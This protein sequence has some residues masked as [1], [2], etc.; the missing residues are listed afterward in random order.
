MFQRQRLEEILKSRGFFL[1]AL[2][3]FFTLSLLVRLWWTLSVQPPAKALYS[4]ML[5]YTDRAQD[6]VKGQ[7]VRNPYL[8]VVAYGAHYFY[9]AEMLVFGPENYK[10]MSVVGAV[11]SAVTVALVMAAARFCFN[12]V[13][14]PYLVGLLCAIWYPAIVFT[15]F[16]STELPFS[17]FL[18]LSILLSFWLLWTRRPA[19]VAVIAGVAYAAGFAIRPQLLMTFL[20]FFVWVV[21]RRNKITAFRWRWLPAFALPVI[22]VVVFSVYRYHYFTGRYA[23]I[24]SNSAVG[25][26]L[27]SSRYKRI[28]CEMDEFGGVRRTRKFQPPSAR[29]LGYTEQF[30]FEGYIGDS[31][32]LN[33]ERKRYW[34]QLAFSEK[35]KLTCRNVLLLAYL[36]TMWPERNHAKQGW[37]KTVFEFWPGLVQYYVFPLAIVGLAVLLFRLNIYLEIVALHFITILYAALMYIGEIRYRIPYDFVFIMLAVYAL[38]VLTRLEHK[39]SPQDIFTKLGRLFSPVGRLLSS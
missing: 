27:A 15:G 22:I 38:A 35:A 17:F 2:I 32:I 23:L 34:S 21:I 10:A 39:D 20:L 14:G 7:Q 25:R 28:V 30:K 11:L 26:L 4:D 29:D 1:A 16:F 24:S 36:N 33:A 37:R 8:G 6:L 12:F 31:V 13:W 19:L 18:Y 5:G 9:A 3:A